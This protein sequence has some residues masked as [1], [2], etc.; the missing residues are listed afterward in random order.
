MSKTVA[1]VEQVV[2]YNLHNN[3]EY[4]R[5]VLPYI[6]AEYFSDI[7]ERVVFETI[8]AYFTKYNVPPSHAALEIELQNLSVA[9]EQHEA[10]LQIAEEIRTGDDKVNA[11][12]LLETTEDFCKDRA[13]HNAIYEA[14][15]ISNGE[16]EHLSKTS[17]PDILGEALAVSFDTN[18]GHDYLEDAQKRL[19]YY[20][21]PIHKTPF[22]I[23]LLNTITNGGVER[24]TANCL[25]AGTGVGKSMLLCDLSAN[26][27]KDGLNVLYISME[28]SEEK[29]AHRIDANLLNKNLDEFNAELDDE[30]FLSKVEKLK[31]SYTGKLRIKEY[32]NGSAHAGHFRHL[33]REMKQKENFIPD[34]VCIDYMN[35][36]ASARMKDR[37]NGYAYVKS[38]CEELRALAQEFNIILWTA[39]QLNRDGNNNSDADI[40]NVS[41]SFGGPMTFDF[42]LGLL[43]TE[44]LAAIKQMKCAQFKNRY[45]DKTKYST[46]TIGFDTDRQRF[47]NI[48]NSSLQNVT[49]QQLQPQTATDSSGGNKLM[50]KKEKLKK[51]KV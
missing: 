24:K 26:Y 46:F 25:A 40:T 21:N 27:L 3:E 38:I 31:S 30:E 23:D 50:S 36:C 29:I 17:I 22:H 16:N 33:L 13:L 42:L 10:V 28:M 37:A 51:L 18:I 41:E 5:A 48:N 19:E 49:K 14:I 35:I 4:A 34:V 47:F 39:T 7:S 11:E 1:N 44:E 12:W 15:M 6:K 20:K 32:P 45:G 43:L 2:L 9:Q 8:S